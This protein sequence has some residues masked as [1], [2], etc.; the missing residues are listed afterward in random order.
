MAFWQWALAVMQNPSL[1][2]IGYKGIQHERTSSNMSSKII[3]EHRVT[4]RQH[5]EACPKK[6][7]HCGMFI[8]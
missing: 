6:L 8:K 1:V 2:K 3:I 5:S 7:P 4:Q